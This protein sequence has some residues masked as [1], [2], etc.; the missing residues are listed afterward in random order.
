MNRRQL[1][2]ATA[3]I[4]GGYAPP[5]ISRSGDITSLKR[6]EGAPLDGW[7]YRPA[8]PKPPLATL[9]S[10]HG[11]SRN[12]REHLI[13]WMPYAD[14]FGL[15]L[16]APDFSSRSFHGYQRLDLGRGGEAPDELLAELLERLPE[17]VG[18]E[19]RPTCLNGFSGGA[20]FAHR[21]LLT[22]PDA[23]QAAVLTAPGWWTLPTTG[24]PFPHGC[25]PTRQKPGGRF[26]PSAWLRIPILVT[27][28]D[29]DTDR[30]GNLRQDP[31]T[32]SQQG[33]HRIERAARW[34][35]QVENLARESGLPARI[36]FEVLPGAG[37]DFM[38]C[39]TAGLGDQ[40]MALL[41]AHG[42][43]GATHP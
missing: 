1:Q 36:R 21:F 22:H 41:H 16:V 31:F 7:C 8:G 3:G 10:V 39:M 19:H 14:H 33:L 6:S 2:S 34:V 23:I 42:W 15:Q 28:G 38:E 4:V 26:D 12:S 35:G 24:L 37:H 5:G 9:V 43:L 29:Q 13:A 11:V 18:F 17:L 30:D 27:A 32:D 20:Q 25:G 40:A